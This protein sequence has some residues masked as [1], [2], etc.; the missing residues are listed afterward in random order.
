MTKKDTV[1]FLGERLT[2]V[3]HGT[4]RTGLGMPEYPPATPFGRLIEWQEDM[5]S[6][7]KHQKAG[8]E[9]SNENRMQF[10]SAR[11]HEEY[12]AQSFVHMKQ[13]VL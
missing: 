1:L 12:Q 8:N 10:V 6:Q 3:S 4:S 2:T 7:I 5:P 9:P 13:G 11:M